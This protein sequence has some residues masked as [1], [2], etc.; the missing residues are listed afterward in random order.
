MDTVEFVK[1]GGR[2]FKAAV[3]QRL[4]VRSGQWALYVLPSSKCGRFEMFRL[5]RDDKRAVKRVWFLPRYENTK[6]LVRGRD[7]KILS[8]FYG[9]EMVGWVAQAMDGGDKPAPLIDGHRRKG[10]AAAGDVVV[11]PDVLAKVV[12]AVEASQ[13]R[14]EWMSPYGQTRRVGRYAPALLAAE[15]KVSED[16]AEAALGQL[17]LDGA[18]MVEMV[19]RRKKM[20]GLVSTALAKRRE[21]EWGEFVAQGLAGPRKAVANA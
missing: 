20:R 5:Y 4:L 1:A 19:D 21:A 2:R 7:H 3:G 11:G 12:A 16:V 10:K 18:L 17:I 15:L 14:R 13:E 9:P 6:R 8:E